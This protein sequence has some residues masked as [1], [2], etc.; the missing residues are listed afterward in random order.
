LDSVGYVQN[1]HNKITKLGLYRCDLK[2]LPP[3]IVKLQNLTSLDL[4]SNQLSNL[5]P[6]IVKLQNLTKLSLHENQLSQFPKALLDLNL[7]VKWDDHW[8][9]E[10]IHVIDN[11]FQTPPVEIV[12][13]GRQAIIDY[14]AA[15]EEEPYRP[16]NESKLILIGDGAVGKTSLLKRL[17]GQEFNPQESQT[18][19]IN[20]NTLS[21]KHQDNDIKLHCWDFGG[22]Q[23]MHATHQFF[24]SK[25]CLY[26]LV[27]DA[28]RETEVDYWLKHIQT[29]G[30]NAPVIIVINKID[31]NPHFNLPQQRKLKKDYPNFKHLCHI[32]CATQ[33]GIDNLN[34]TIQ[35][36]LPDIE[37]LNTP[38][39]EKWFKVKTAIS[40]QA[41]KTNFTS[42]E[43]Y[44]AICQDN[45]ITEEN[46]QNTLINFLHDLGLINHFQDRRLRETN[47]I[48]PQWITEAVYKI[49]NAKQLADNGKLH[50]KDLKTLLDKTTY[51][52]RKHDYI[53][54]LMKKF[55]LCY[56]LN[57]DEYL[58]PDLFSTQEPKF[59]F[60]DEQALHFIV[61]YDFLP[62]SIFTRFI[63]RMHSHILN[64]THWRSG[65]LL[66][67]PA[68][69]T[70]AL[71]ETHT[72]FKRI[73]LKLTG[74]QKR[75]YLVILRFILTDIHSSFS[76]LSVTE[77]IG[78][79]DSQLSVSYKHLLKL[80][81]KGTKEYD[82]EDSEKSYNIKEL[83]G[84]IAAPASEAETM[85][86][87]QNIINILE[88]QGTKEEKDL[89]DHFNEVVK[90]Q[91]GLCGMS[92][93]VN[94]AI[95]KLIPKS[96]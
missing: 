59:E 17:L 71:I 62:K 29:F 20:I 42:Y 15:L 46:E 60:D 36:T 74:P 77:K 35:N 57:D 43:Q 1:E 45:G 96:K 54:E 58:L 16:L 76:H 39:P 33:E 5:P 52:E 53:I 41:K 23:I 67:D 6:E 34:S 50:R 28:R 12:K 95:R 72:K 68:T 65:V 91:P 3:E 83:L 25:R 24:L 7:E 8:Y 40:E 51:P 30:K 70:T 84:I 4:G 69:D 78:L 14:Y 82:P 13:Q 63:V 80:D 26:L 79:P 86:M 9:D 32:S 11:P 61:E 27:L 66:K 37:L 47:V 2:E 92:I 48:N 81:K 73:E 21:F 19:G 89:L 94:A 88:T 75:E 18:H 49:I 10:G 85:Q 93:D 22:Q 64:N 38:F 55:E 56:A 90:L 44:V 31:E 87:L